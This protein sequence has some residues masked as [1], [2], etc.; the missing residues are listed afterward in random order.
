M[1]EDGME[2]WMEDGME[3]GNFERISFE[4]GKSWGRML[5]I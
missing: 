3:N 4:S 1:M 5:G 2:G